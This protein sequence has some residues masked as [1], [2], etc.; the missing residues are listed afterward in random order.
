MAVLTWNNLVS[1]FENVA[2]AHQQIN[3]YGL[4]EEWEINGATESNR[5]YPKMWVIPIDSITKE[6]TVERTFEFLVFDLV[7]PDEDNENDV[8]SDTE[9]IIHD[10]IKVFKNE[11]DNYNVTNEPQ[12][13]YFTEKYADNVSGWRAQITIETDFASNSCDMPMDDFVSPSINNSVLILNQDGNT[14]ATLYG[15]QTYT[16]SA[17]Y[18]DTAENYTV[19]GTTQ[20]VLQTPVF[21]YGVFLNGQRLTVTTDYTVSGTTITFNTALASDLVTIVY[22]Y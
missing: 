13:F 3:S 2:T 12:A 22:N 17:T 19:T 7:H 16:L 8:V 18:M 5:D 20:S 9:Q 1:L 11:S 10:I 14:V 4:G 6:Q 15:G 21:I